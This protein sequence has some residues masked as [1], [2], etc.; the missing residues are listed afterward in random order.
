MPSFSAVLTPACWPVVGRASLPVEA[1]E[2][3]A[4]N[5]GRELA[6]SVRS[7]L[8]GRGETAGVGF[9]RPL[10]KLAGVGIRIGGR[11]RVCACSSKFMFLTYAETAANKSLSRAMRSGGYQRGFLL[12]RF[13]AALR[14]K[15]MPSLICARWQKAPRRNMGFGDRFTVI[16]VHQ[17]IRFEGR[18]MNSTRA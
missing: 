2:L 12:S 15:A 3:I 11:P 18:V 5:G 4:D 13:S 14:R 1:A 9:A 17:A 7:G 6:G 16:E 10:M 8:A